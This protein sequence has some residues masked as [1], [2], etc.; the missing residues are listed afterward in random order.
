MRHILAS[1]IMLSSMLIPAVAHA[2]SSADDATA[3]TS[4]LRVSTGVSAPSIVGPIAIQLPENM[5]ASFVQTDTQIGLS[6]T[7]DS[8]GLPQNVKVVKSSN[9]F[10]DARVVDAIQKSHFH[11]GTVDETPIPVEMNLTVSVAR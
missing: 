9:P 1:S 3:P 2:T 11:P 10:L 5:S 4:N 7:V 8:N 6:L